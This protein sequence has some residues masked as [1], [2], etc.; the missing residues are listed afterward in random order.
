VAVSL[1]TGQLI[2]HDR[3]NFVL[4]RAHVP[5]A[6]AAAIRAART[7]LGLLGWPGGRMPVESVGP[8][9]GRGKVRQVVFGW[10]GLHGVAV[11]Q[12][13]LWVTPD[14][15]IVEAWLWPPVRAGGSVPS[16]S[17]PTAWTKLRAGRLP[18]VVAG[19]RP[20]TQA[21]GD[22]VLRQTAAVLIPSSGG[23][24]KAYL[25]PAYRF[26]GRVRLQSSSHSYPWYGLAPGQSK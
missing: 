25:V 5:P 22:G 3:R 19:V 13:T 21:P 6:P 24:G 23:P 17:L 12:A 9:P 10:S 20:G 11:P 15:S 14:R 2:Y 4:P 18:L 8:A 1:G 26:S 7:W 16:V